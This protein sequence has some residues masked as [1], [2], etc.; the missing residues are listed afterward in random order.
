MV[1]AGTPRVALVDINRLEVELD[2]PVEVDQRKDRITGIEYTNGTSVPMKLKSLTPK[3]DGTQLYRMCL[4][5]EGKTPQKLTAGMNAS[6]TLRMASEGQDGTFT[7][8]MHAVFKENGNTYVWTIGKDSLARKVQVALQ[9]MDGNG[10]AVI[11]SGLKG[12]EQVVR[13]GVNA[14]QENEKVSITPQPAKTNVGGL[15]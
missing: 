3:A 4:A 10:Q 9:G 6:I 12:D 8:P 13:A 1:E 7:L 15:L 14:L 2:I 11:S 5:F